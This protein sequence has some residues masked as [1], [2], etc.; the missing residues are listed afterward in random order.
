MLLL[1]FSSSEICVLLDLRRSENAVWNFSSVN[2]VLFGDL[3]EEWRGAER[4]VEEGNNEWTP[5]YNVLVKTPHVILG[6]T[7]KFLGTTETILVLCLALKK[8]L[9]EFAL[10]SLGFKKTV[11]RQKGLREEPEKSFD[12]YGVIQGSFFVWFINRKSVLT[13]VQ[14]YLQWNRNL[15]PGFSI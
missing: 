13:V 5:K 6:Y 14:K 4:F 9:L 11:G 1:P 8:F 2:K 3:E 12:S 7:E 10:S 15:I